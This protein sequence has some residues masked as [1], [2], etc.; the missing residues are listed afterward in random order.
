MLLG[1]LSQYKDPRGQIHNM[2]K[3]GLLLPVKQGVYLVSEDLGQRPYSKAILANLIYGPSYVSLETALSHYGFI[4]ERVETTSSVC[5]GNSRTFETP[6]GTFEY[7]HVKD[8]LYPQGVTIKEVFKDAFC[9]FAVPEKAL[10]DFIYLREKKEKFKNSKEYIKYIIDSYRFDMDFIKEKILP[11]KLKNLS[12][13]YSP[14]RIHWFV[15]ELL[16][17]LSK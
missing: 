12:T 13:L 2:V 3:K 16:R 9:S 7:C 1:M 5:I 8:I 15:S 14:L 17:R 4:P 6:I 10:L 11:K